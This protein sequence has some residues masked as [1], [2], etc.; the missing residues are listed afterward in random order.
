MKHL[1]GTLA[2]LVALTF[3]IGCSGDASATEAVSSVTDSEVAAAPAFRDPT[4]QKTVGSGAAV[5]HFVCPDRCAD[6]HADAEGPCPTCGKGLLHNDAFHWKDGQRPPEPQPLPAEMLPP[7]EP[8]QNA[9]GV[10][11]YTCAQGCAGGSG[12]AEACAGCGEVLAHNQT[13]HQ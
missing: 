8:D 6:G 7:P 4:P 9:A 2:S 11:H 12:K 13:Y 10:W 1:L 5:R 3:L